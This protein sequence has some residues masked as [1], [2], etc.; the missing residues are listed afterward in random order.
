[1]P[2][3]TQP[4]NG[5]I[6]LTSDGPYD[7]ANVTVDGPLVIRAA[8]GVRPHVIVRGGPL[9]ITAAQVLIQR[10]HFTSASEDSPVLIAVQCRRLL[11][12]GCRF[13]AALRDAPG[14]GAAA[15]D[16]ASATAIAWK[17]TDPANPTGGE[18]RMR[19]SHIDGALHG[20]ETHAMPR[21]MMFDNCLKTGA[22]SLIRFVHEGRSAPLTVQLHQ[23]TLRESSG[24]V[25][26]SE[27]SSREAVQP[28]SIIAQQC[29]FDV[30]VDKGALLGFAGGPPSQGWEGLVRLSGE[31][32]LVRAG[33]LLAASRLQQP[34][35]PA[36]VDTSQLRVDGLLSDDFEFA[37]PGS[38]DPQA[39][40]IAFTQAPRSSPTP[41]G[42][43]ADALIR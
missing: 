25:Q 17:V 36:T 35:A 12:E 23:S 18:L 15:N 4:L 37:G 41:P 40:A 21:G 13:D 43:D 42:I 22:G 38:D 16:R 7:A 5:V 32:S 6:E 19:N 8:D 2:F 3:P 30:P 14:G 26:W 9:R 34:G 31:G 28:L 29:V 1:M 11:V 24:I 10:V 39:S 27:R 20:V 33:T